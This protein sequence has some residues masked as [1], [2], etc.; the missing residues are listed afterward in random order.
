[1]QWAIGLSQVPC[2][3]TA[4]LDHPTRLVIDFLPGSS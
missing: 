2:F 1:M 3:R 4:Y